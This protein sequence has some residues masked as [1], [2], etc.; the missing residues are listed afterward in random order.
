MMK[1]ILH[2]EG[3]STWWRLFQIR[4]VHTKLDIYVFIS[5]TMNFCVDFSALF[6]TDISCCWFL[7]SIAYRY[8]MLFIF[9]T[10]FITDISTP[11]QIISIYVSNTIKIFRGSKNSMPRGFLFRINIIWQ[12]IASRYLL[13]R[14]YVSTLRALCY[15]YFVVWVELWWIVNYHVLILF[16][17]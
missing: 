15:C 14:F 12:N 1:V 2:D 8:F 4:V 10:L 3:Y 7:S 9:S 6:I 17:N 5:K 16:S 13:S 11:L